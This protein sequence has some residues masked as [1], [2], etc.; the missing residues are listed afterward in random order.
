MEGVRLLERKE[1]GKGARDGVARFLYPA[2]A[3]AGPCTYLTRCGGRSFLMR[4]CRLVVY[5][6]IFS[7]II[8]LL[9]THDYRLKI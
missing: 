1:E 9:V 3:A 7:V 2:K 6:F 8:L 4:A 5:V